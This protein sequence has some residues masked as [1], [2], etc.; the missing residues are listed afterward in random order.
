MSAY[1]R[2]VTRLIVLSTLIVGIYL[3]KPAN[4]AA[5]ACPGGTICTTQ[6]QQCLASCGTNAACK[7]QCKTD[8]GDCCSTR[9]SKQAGLGTDINLSRHVTWQSFLAS[10]Q[11]VGNQNSTANLAESQPK[12]SSKLNLP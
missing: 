4:A 9:F 6:Y 2:V 10:G 5:F 7:T 11:P 1:S 3:L 12:P 8:L